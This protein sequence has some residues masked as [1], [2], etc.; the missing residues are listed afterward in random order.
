[1]GVRAVFMGPKLF[2]YDKEVKNLTLSY[3]SGDVTGRRGPSLAPPCNTRPLQRSA[4]FAADFA[5]EFSGPR[6]V[7]AAAYAMLTRAS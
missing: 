4:H 6:L 3:M 2:R 5:P 7:R 1:M